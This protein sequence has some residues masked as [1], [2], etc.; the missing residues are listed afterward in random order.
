MDHDHAD[1]RL[2]AG[3]ELVA[4]L[5]QDFIREPWVQALDL[6]TLDESAKDTLADGRLSPV[7]SPVLWCVGA[8]S[9]RVTRHAT[10]HHYPQ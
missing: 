6:S 2:F 5:L 1:K 9:P 10:A 8:L 7:V 3:P 4:D